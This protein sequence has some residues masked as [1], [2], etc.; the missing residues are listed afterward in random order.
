VSLKKSCSAWFAIYLIAAIVVGAL[1]YRRCPLVGAAL[2]GGAVGGGIVWLGLAYL[3][4]V[5]TKI[6]EAVRVRDTN[7]GGPPP[8]GETIAVVG[9]IEPVGPTL[10]SP[11]TGKPCVAYKYEVKRGE[12]ML[13]DGFALTPSAVL[14]SHGQIRILAYPTLEVRPHLVPNSEAVPNFSAYIERTHFKKPDLADVR[15]VLTGP[16][17]AFNSDEGSI[18]T[19][20]RMADDD[21]KIDYATYTEWSLAPGDRVFAT[22]RYSLERGAL[23]PE[24]GMPLSV[25]LRDATRGVAGRSIAGAFGNLIGAL[26]F[27]AVAAAG[28][29]GLYAFVPLAASEQMSPT[30]TPTWRE[31]RLDRLLER[32][33][34]PRLREAGFLDSGTVVADPPLGSARGRV[35]A[36]GRDVVVSRA[37]ATRLGDLYTI[38][39]DDDVLVLTID[40]YGHP[41]RL[42]FGSQ[43]VDPRRDLEMNMTGHVSGRVTYM[44]DDAE[45]PACRVTF[46]AT[47][48]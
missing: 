16:P 44:R 36:N 45:T 14:S 40:E 42:R 15:A 17:P 7:D 11:F 25:I 12:T 46:Q 39:I 34:R 8:D 9:A 41:I 33:V 24:P 2:G 35:T 47:L 38:H 6:L 21:A 28:L 1:V 4:G 31:I 30:L 27:F 23:V 37:T 48:Q 26:I 5:R 32:R 13:Y 10:T 22:G 18:R 3:A 20:T 19:D 29:L 43:D